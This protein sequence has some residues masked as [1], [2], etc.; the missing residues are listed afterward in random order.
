M[1]AGDGAQCVADGLVGRA[2]RRVQSIASG[3]ESAAA[4]LSSVRTAADVAA[5]G[6]ASA[7]A[8]E[9]LALLTALR[10]EDRAGDAAAAAAEATGAG[11]ATLT[12]AAVAFGGARQREEDL[13]GGS[14]LDNM[15]R[16]MGSASDMSAYMQHVPLLNQQLDMCADGKLD[17]KKYPLGA[18]PA[19]PSPP[20]IRTSNEQGNQT[21]CRA[22]WARCCLSRGSEAS[23]GHAT[24]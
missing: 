19:R 5:A 1:V 8:V 7:A 12:A 24:D 21:C 22:L 13:F 10:H 2:D 18:H 20:C 9:R 15:K 6:G 16:M 11:T 23:G 4:S 3:S 17:L 14:L